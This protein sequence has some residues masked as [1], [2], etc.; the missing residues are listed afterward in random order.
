MPTL[1]EEL[2]R[3][4]EERGIT[5]NDISEATRI[6]TRFLKAIESDSFSILPGGI[7]TRNFIRAFAEQVGMAEEEAMSLYHQQVTGQSAEPG[8]Q[9]SSLKRPSQPLEPPLRRR[10]PLT[11]GQ[12]PSRTNWATIIIG[13]GIAVFLALILLAVVKKMEQE[14]PSGESQTDSTPEVESPQPETPPSPSPQTANPQQADQQAPPSDTLR[15]R[16]EAVNGDSYIRYQA[17]NQE[18]VTITLKQG[19]VLE[20]PPAQNEV[21]LV[22]GNRLA[23]KL[24]VNDREARFPESA[25]KFGGQVIIS[26][27]TLESYF[28]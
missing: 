15:V 12:G 2:K 24:V 1:G 6:G 26:R 13:V 14:T 17:D 23:L 28:Q 16:F 4:R 7:Y 22:Y 21:K 19:Q 10:E 11:Y 25:P 20:I 3:R 27:E 18:P 9:V 8:A 5:L